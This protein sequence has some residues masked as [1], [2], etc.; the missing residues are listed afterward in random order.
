VDPEGPNLIDRKAFCPNCGA[1]RE[2]QLVLKLTGALQAAVGNELDRL[3]GLILIGIREK[4]RQGNASRTADYLSDTL[5]QFDPLLKVL[6]RS[7]VQQ[8]GRVL[9]EPSTV[10]E[11]T[12][13][14][15]QLACIECE[16]LVETGTWLEGT[17]VDEITN[18][19]EASFTM[20]VTSLY[21]YASEG[22]AAS[23]GRMMEQALRQLHF[24]F[25][26]LEWQSLHAEDL[27][28]REI[29]S[30]EWLRT[31]SS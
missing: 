10:Q 20:L 3:L 6:G 14:T 23:A 26:A 11:P 8:S 1:L 18:N 7:L 27:I 15:R 9:L 31:R 16:E 19:V 2:E 30:D 4:A 5:N 29:I 13:A 12:G 25:E 22:K 21:K 17:E 24:C 28:Y